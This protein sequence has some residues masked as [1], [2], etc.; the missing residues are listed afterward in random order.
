MIFNS[1][2]SIQSSFKLTK[3]IQTA[4]RKTAIEWHVVPATT[5]I[6]QIK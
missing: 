4:Y 2:S 1:E 5:N 3:D 6:C